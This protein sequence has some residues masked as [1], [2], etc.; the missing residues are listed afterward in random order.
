M[1]NS[2]Q[3]ERIALNLIIDEVKTRPA[4]SARKPVRSDV[5]SALSL[6]HDPN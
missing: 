5:I 3:V 1:H 4:L 6:D 2:E